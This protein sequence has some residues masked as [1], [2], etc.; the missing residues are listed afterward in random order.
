[1]AVAPIIFFGIIFTFNEEKNSK[2]F[3]PLFLTI[4]TLLL[5]TIL[6]SAIS[7]KFLNAKS[8]HLEVAIMGDEIAVISSMTGDNLLPWVKHDDIIECSQFEIFFERAL[9]FIRKGYDTSG[10]LVTN[11]T[12]ES[13]HELWL[14][15]ISNNP[16]LYF[17]IKANNFLFFIRSPSLAPYYIWH[18]GIDKNKYSIKLLHPKITEILAKYVKGSRAYAPEIFKPYFWLMTALLMIFLSYFSRDKI[19]KTQIIAL[20][21]SALGYFF[22]YFLVGVSADFRYIYWCIICISI[23]IVVFLSSFKFKNIFAPEDK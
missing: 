22:S 21:C 11:N 9:C 2:F 17:K 1:L 15:A 5:F 13:T 8:G 10:S 19:A 23:S 7:Y 12:I 16:V 3:K 4:I 14:K 20:N 18:E 6:N